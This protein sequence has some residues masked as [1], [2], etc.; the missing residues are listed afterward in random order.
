MPS[1]PV[2]N[3]NARAAYRRL[4]S[5][6]K[7]G[8][9]P[10]GW[11]RTDEAGSTLAQLREHRGDQTATVA[12]QSTTFGVVTGAPRRVKTYSPPEKSMPNSY[13]A[14]SSSSVTASSGGIMDVVSEAYALERR[15]KSSAALARTPATFRRCHVEE[16]FGRFER[17]A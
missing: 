13:A 9:K 17:A 10:N 6:A 2:G 3:L 7:F 8:W 15:A 4:R 12:G 16:R 5:V 11:N 14:A 1:S